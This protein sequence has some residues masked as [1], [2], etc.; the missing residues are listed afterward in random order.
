MTIPSKPAAAEIL[1]FASARKRRM[2][3]REAERPFAERV[4]EAKRRI[5]RRSGLLFVLDP[6]PL[7]G[8]A[9]ES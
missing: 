3:K 5:L 4:E 7:D 9:F 8:A 2:L 1:D 6:K